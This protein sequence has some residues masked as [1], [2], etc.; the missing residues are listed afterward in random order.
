MVKTNRGDKLLNSDSFNTISLR[1]D[2]GHPIAVVPRPPDKL[3]RPNYRKEAAVFL[4]SN[5][6]HL[7]TVAG[8]AIEKEKEVSYGDCARDPRG[9]AVADPCS[10]LLCPS[11]RY[12]WRACVASCLWSGLAQPTA[13]SASLSIG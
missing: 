2:L 1:A 6:A 7:Y 13:A 3:A 8:G 5:C 9:R 12:I 10:A 4:W 11:F